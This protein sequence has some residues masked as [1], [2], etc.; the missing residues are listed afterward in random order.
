MTQTS[1]GEA[2]L[3]AAGCPLDEAEAYVR[4]Q[5]RAS[6]RRPMQDGAAH[7][8]KGA[9]ASRVDPK[10]GPVTRPHVRGR[11][12]DRLGGTDQERDEEIFSGNRTSLCH[13]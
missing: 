4:D 9:E 3:L 12:R 5:R 1:N 13:A 6:A 8:P 10:A 2:R 7:I 11:L